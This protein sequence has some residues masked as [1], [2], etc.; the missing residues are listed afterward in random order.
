MTTCCWSDEA[1]A[2]LQ[3]L[4]RDG[5]VA[6]DGDASDAV[7]RCVAQAVNMKSQSHV[8]YW[9]QP[10]D[11]DVEH[12]TRSLRQSFLDFFAQLLSHAP[13]CARSAIDALWAAVD[14]AAARGESSR[15]AVQL[16]ALEAL[17]LACAWEEVYGTQQLL[18]RLAAPDPVTAALAA[19]AACTVATTHAGTLVE[20]VGAL[21][22]LKKL[23]SPE[24]QAGRKLLPTAL[25]DLSEILFVLLPCTPVVAEGNGQVLAESYGQLAPAAPNPFI[26][27]LLR[28]L[29]VAPGI[30]K[31]EILKVLEAVATDEQKIG[32][33]LEAL[34]GLF[35]EADLC[36]HRKGLELLDMAVDVL[37]RLGCSGAVASSVEPLLESLIRRC[38]LKCHWT[39]SSIDLQALFRRLLWRLVAIL[40]G[41]RVE[42][43]ERIALGFTSG[44]AKVREESQKLFSEIPKAGEAMKEVKRILLD[45][46]DDDFN[47]DACCIA[48]QLLESEMPDPDLEDRLVRLLGHPSPLVR[49]ATV[50]VL[51][52]ASAHRLEVLGPIC[53]EDEEPFVRLGTLRVLAERLPQEELLPLLAKTLEDPAPSV[54]HFSL[55]CFQEHGLQPP[56]FALRRAAQHVDPQLRRVAA[57]WAADAAT[58]WPETDPV[59]LELQRFRRKGVLERLSIRRLDGEVLLLEVSSDSTLRDLKDRLREVQLREAQFATDEVTVSLTTVELLLQGEVL[60]DNKATVAELGLSEEQDLQVLYSLLDAALDLP[61]IKGGDSTIPKSKVRRRTPA[62]GLQTVECASQEESGCEKEDLR[63]VVVPE[64]YRYVTCDPGLLVTSEISTTPLGQR[65]V[66]ANCRSLT[67]VLIP[68][69]ITTIEKAVFRGCSALRSVTLP[70]LVSSIGIC[71]FQ[72]CSCLD[73]ATINIPDS[74]VAIGHKAFENCRSLVMLTLPNSIVSVGAG[75]FAGCALEKVK[76]LERGAFENC[77]ALTQVQVPQTL[78]C[79]TWTPRRPS[80]MKTAIR[81]LVLVS[82]TLKDAGLVIL[83]LECID[84]DAVNVMF[85]TIVT[86]CLPLA[87]AGDHFLQKRAEDCDVTGHFSCNTTVFDEM[88]EITF[89]PNEKDEVTLIKNN[90]AKF[91]R[92]GL[93]YGVD[94]HEIQH[95]AKVPSPHLT[96]RCAIVETV[97]QDPNARFHDAFTDYV[98][99]DDC[100][101]FTKVGTHLSNTAV[102]NVECF[103]ACTGD[104]ALVVM[105]LVTTFFMCI[106]TYSFNTPERY[107]YIRVSLLPV[108]V[109]VSVGIALQSNQLSQYISVLADI[110]RELGCVVGGFLDRPSTEI[111][112][113]LSIF[114]LVIDFI[115]GDLFWQLSRLEGGVTVL[116]GLEV[117]DILPARVFLCAREGAAH[118]DDVLGHRIG[119]T[120]EVIGCAW[121]SRYSL[122]ADLKCPRCK[123]NS[124]LICELRRPRMEELQAL[125]QEKIGLHKSAGMWDDFQEN[126]EDYGF[127]SV[128]CF[129][130]DRPNFA[131]LE[132]AGEGWHQR[133]EAIW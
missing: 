64:G 46:L 13:H 84:V 8:A 61:E 105:M 65:G 97:G 33:L 54:I 48:L 9:E 72:S 115:L 71:A 58:P 38:T 87:W 93:H 15:N 39:Y 99:N 122:I 125:V 40:G 11:S 6:I 128:K 18:P 60:Q 29:R 66:F 51:R 132:Q 131:A 94:N 3:H 92:V 96:Y 111:F 31:V 118:L 117:L 73:Q 30:H 10:V 85:I 108:R 49:A 103:L 50:E 133:T 37:E 52:G 26:T 27:P 75:A 86:M 36:T 119:I 4:T 100:S 21:I 1:L 45:V 109:A 113:Y 121:D 88:G 7:V 34:R 82:S 90:Y 95:C 104:S 120:T 79:S 106:I 123:M 98:F 80:A 102:V 12:P 2:A 116:L 127:L 32:Q 53:L 47:S 62:P 101:A 28:E 129:S 68:D 77:G 70:S 25:V 78:S 110:I 74:V 59:V 57:R 35:Q 44:H 81:V 67:S 5:R 17:K 55:E 16:E 41:S 69:S 19:R 22:Q 107:D 43:L 56:A 24:L 114:V 42:D 14:G 130:T 124:G 20:A 23:R 89:Y 91:M 63:V 76:H 112:S 126:Q 83:S